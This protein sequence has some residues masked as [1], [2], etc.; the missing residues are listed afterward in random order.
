MHCS[1]KD[2]IKHGDR[3]DQIRRFMGHAT[4][5]GRIRIEFGAKAV[6]NP[7]ALYR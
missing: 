4:W 3:S 6:G 2:V 5:H 1:Q 7:L